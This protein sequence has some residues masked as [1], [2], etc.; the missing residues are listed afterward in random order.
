ML[1]RGWIQHKIMKSKR[2]STSLP[3]G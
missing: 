3:I 2:T 1:F